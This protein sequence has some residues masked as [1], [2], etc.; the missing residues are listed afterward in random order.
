[1]K[2]TF[3]DTSAWLAL[4]NKSDNFHEKAKFTRDNLMKQ[5][6]KFVVT[7]YVIAEI[8]NC[9]SRLNFRKAG[10][11]LIENIRESE[12]IEIIKP[13]CPESPSYFV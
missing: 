11:K 10:I 13:G 1:M 6:S 5:N 3:V 12:D 2:L 7:D 8:G 4:I 9:L